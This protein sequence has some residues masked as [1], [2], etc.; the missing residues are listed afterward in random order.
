MLCTSRHTHTHTYPH[1]VLDFTACASRQS[2][3]WLSTFVLRHRAVTSAQNAIVT[4]DR[5]PLGILR[6][7]VFYHLV[8]LPPVWL[9]VLARAPHWDFRSPM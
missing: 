8:G 4:V 7:Q 9:H 5:E 2:L 1:S 3:V 6:Q